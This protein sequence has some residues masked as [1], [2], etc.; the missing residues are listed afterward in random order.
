MCV[1]KDALDF[2]PTK[3]KKKKLLFPHVLILLGEHQATVLAYGQTGSGKN[4]TMVP[5]PKFRGVRG[6]AAVEWRVRWRME[7]SPRPCL[8]RWC[9]DSSKTVQGVSFILGCQ[10]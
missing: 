6:V 1:L 8:K 4:Y 9:Q 2:Q 3:K 5:Q 10:K 7:S